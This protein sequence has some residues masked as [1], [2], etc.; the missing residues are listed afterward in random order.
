[1]KDKNPV[2]DALLKLT[3]DMPA[4]RLGLSDADKTLLVQKI[5]PRT[6]RSI[7]SMRGKVVAAR[8]PFLFSSVDTQAV[9]DLLANDCEAEIQHALKKN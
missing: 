6:A 8:I 2:A 3:G 7:L 1:M 4:P 5:G 9:V